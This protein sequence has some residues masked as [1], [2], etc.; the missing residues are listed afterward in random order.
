MKKE[1]DKPD[2]YKPTGGIAPFGYRWENAQLIVDS[3]EASIR[4]LIYELFLKHRRKKTVA[5]ILNESGYRTRKG[6]K[7]SD[8]TI[9][10]LLRDTTAK[11]I[12]I[13]AEQEIKVEAIVDFETWE[14]ANNL[15]G[16]KV[17]KRSSDLFSGLI[18]CFCGTKMSIPSSSKKYVCISCKHK[19][20]VKIVKE[21]FLDNLEKFFAKNLEKISNN[22]EASNNQTMDYWK[23]LTKSEKRILTQNLI[24][25]ITVETDT[26]LITFGIDPN[27]F[28]AAVFGQQ[29]SENTKVL[30]GKQKLGIT[31]ERS[32]PL[33]SE[34]EG[35][36]FLGVSKMTLLRYRKAKKIGHFRIGFR[37]LYSKEKHLLPFLEERER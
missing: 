32:E 13:N 30:E 18:F 21:A 4:K 31:N 12:R 25:K 34:A 19:I 35:A 10:R 23:L 2:S 24:N 11:G 8:T 27:S 16:K 37:V 6:A 15:L 22:N 33:M 14:R 29:N 26:I 5:E 36:K 17:T 1:V 7:F 3:E 28:K 9:D 20:E